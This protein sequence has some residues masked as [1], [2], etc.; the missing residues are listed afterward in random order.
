MKQKKKKNK[1]KH[2]VVDDVIVD[3]KALLGSNSI[4]M[5]S[6]CYCSGFRTL[7]Q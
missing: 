1:A 6:R 3:D 4:K 7:P 5:V 2:G